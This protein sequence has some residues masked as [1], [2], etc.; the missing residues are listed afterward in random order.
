VLRWLRQI[1]E[2]SLL[3]NDFPALH[4]LRLL[5]IVSVIQVHVTV[6]FLQT[7]LLRD[8]GFAFHSLAIDFGMDLFFVMS[9]FLIGTMLFRSGT[10]APGQDRGRLLRFYARR[11]FR[12]FPPFYAVLTWHALNEALPI[13]REHLWKEYLYLG[14]Y[15]PGFAALPVMPWAWSLCVEEHFYLLIPLLVAVLTRLRSHAARITLLVAGWCSA[16]VVRLVT[17]YS[18]HGRWS[19]DDLLGKIF[20]RTHCRY[21]VLLAGVLLAYLQYSFADRMRALYTRRWIRWTSMAFVAACVWLLVHPSTGPHEQLQR[22]FYWGTVTSL[23]YFVLVPLT[24]NT[25]GLLTRAFGWRPLQWLA[26]L[27]YGMYLVHIPLGRYRVVPIAGRLRMA[28]GISDRPLWVIGVVLLVTLSIIGA[29]VLHL[30]VEKPM[31]WLRD[32]IAPSLLHAKRTER[33]LASRLAQGT[34]L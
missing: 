26:T 1:F 34:Q 20:I 7:R 5:A 14:N 2:P 4:G 12:V 29:Y 9:G 3:A 32:R 25:D 19:D 28:Y 27:S 6:L 16:L 33:P 13:Q 10:A 11:S 22:M 18:H 15:A 31:L 17:Y 23:M 21:D 24:I 8:V 30:A